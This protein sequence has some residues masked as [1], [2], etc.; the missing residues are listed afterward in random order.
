MQALVTGT[1]SFYILSPL[2]VAATREE[3]YLSCSIL[4]VVSLPAEPVKNKT[5]IT[6]IRIVAKPSSILRTI[7]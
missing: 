1:S 6:R 4:D 3:K 5:I 2:G 7:V